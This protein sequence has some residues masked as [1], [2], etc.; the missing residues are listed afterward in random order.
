M[1]RISNIKRF[2]TK[3][4]NKE[5]TTPFAWYNTEYYN[6]SKEEINDMNCYYMNKNFIRCMVIVDNIEVTRPQRTWGTMP[7]WFRPN[8]MIN[9][10]DGY[11]HINCFIFVIYTSE[12]GQSITL[13]EIQKS[14]ESFPKTSKILYYIKE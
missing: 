13:E 3:V 2:F 12:W 14:L 10:F 4:Y 7:E 9:T 5:D 6:L 8:S 1:K 11:N